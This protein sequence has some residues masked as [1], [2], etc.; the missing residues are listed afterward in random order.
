MNNPVKKRFHLVNAM[1]SGRS[2]LGYERILKQIL[3][4]HN[5]EIPTVY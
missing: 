2:P 3:H 1:H 4:I 5:V